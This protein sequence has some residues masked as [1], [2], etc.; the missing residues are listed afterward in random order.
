MLP[1]S[2][3]T[4]GEQSYIKGDVSNVNGDIRYKIDGDIANFSPFHGF[5]GISL[6]CMVCS[7]R[8]RFKTVG[9]QPRTVS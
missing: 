6:R 5:Q 4:S 9:R 1:L 2:P 7:L 8:F 3:L